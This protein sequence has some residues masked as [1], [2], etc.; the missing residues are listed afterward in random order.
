MQFCGPHV[1]Y[2][3]DIPIWLG[4]VL[5]WHKIPVSNIFYHFLSADQLDSKA[6]KMS[7][8]FRLDCKIDFQNMF[9]IKCINFIID[10]CSIGP[11]IILSGI[12]IG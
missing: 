4:Q 12:Y 2:K 11:L 5:K 7:E 9:H 3:N 8:N 6:S 1:G 10:T